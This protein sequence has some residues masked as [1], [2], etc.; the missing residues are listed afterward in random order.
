MLR[1]FAIT[2]ITGKVGGATARAL[3]EA[4]CKVRAVVRDKSRGVAWYSRGCELA[5]ADIS[6][7]ASLAEA[8]TGAEGTFIL[9][10]PTFDPAPDFSD[11]K[12]AEQQ[13]A[14]V[15]RAETVLALFSDNKSP[16]W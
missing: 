2:G 12:A 1:K 11:V 4:G 3:L 16:K 14:D 13:R 9:L 10:P 6:N 5:V 8:L 15:A 7:A